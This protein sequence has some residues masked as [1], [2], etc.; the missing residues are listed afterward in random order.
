METFKF[1]IR[2][3]CELLGVAIPQ[4]LIGYEKQEVNGIEARYSQLTKQDIYFDIDPDEE[5]FAKADEIQCYFIVTAKKF[6]LN[7]I[8]DFQLSA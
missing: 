7:F 3:I 1:T 6:N 2:E 4:S 8:S 5:S